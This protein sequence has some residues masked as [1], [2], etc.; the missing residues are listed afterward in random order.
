[1]HAQNPPAH[2]RPAGRPTSPS[3]PSPSG[4]RV[5]SGASVP[6]TASGPAR[7]VSFA[8]R[9]V[10][11]SPTLAV[12]EALARKRREGVRVLPLGFGEAGIP[13]HPAL[14]RELASASG[15]GGYGPVAGSAALRAA[16]AG[17][18]ARRGLPTDPSTVVCGPGGVAD[19]REAAASLAPLK[20]AAKALHGASWV[21]GRAG[22][23]GHEIR[24]GSGTYPA[25][26]GHATVEP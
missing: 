22:L 1:M 2:E 25:Q 23:P 7:P 10:P 12:N 24:R 15:R 13:I 4:P 17:Y 8:P 3:S 18:W 11:L 6:S 26:A 19:H 5:S 14:T 16:A 21:L 20:K 9:A